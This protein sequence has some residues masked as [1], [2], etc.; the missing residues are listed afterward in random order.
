MATPSGVV[1][2]SRGVTDMTHGHISEGTIRA[3]AAKDHCEDH[4]NHTT[5]NS[6][7]GFGLAGG[8]YGPY[9]ICGECGAILGKVEVEDE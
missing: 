7:G 2:L 1:S 8:G 6:E 9:Y 3:R 5:E 4:P